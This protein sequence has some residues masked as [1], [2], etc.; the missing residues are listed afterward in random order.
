M[1]VCVVV[2]NVCVCVCV[3]VKHTQSEIIFDV[4]IPLFFF[5]LVFAGGRIVGVGE[6]EDP[7]TAVVCV[8]ACVCERERAR[9]RVR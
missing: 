3:C 2:H 6:I 4:C 5:I 1:C 8:C 7:V 9:E